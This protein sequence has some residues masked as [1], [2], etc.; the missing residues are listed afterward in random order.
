MVTHLN[1][2]KLSFITYTLLIIASPYLTAQTWAD[3]CLFLFIGALIYQFLFLCHFSVKENIRSSRSLFL[4]FVCAI[5]SVG[6]YIILYYNKIFFFGYESC[7]FLGGTCSGVYY[8]FEA[9]RRDA[10]SSIVY[11]PYLIFNLIIILKYYRSTKKS[12]NNQSSD[13][14]TYVNKDELNNNE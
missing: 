11:I 5:S 10:W 14:T 3:I 9:I 6:L 4:Y 12:S 8:G 7:G 13:D 2:F 1:I